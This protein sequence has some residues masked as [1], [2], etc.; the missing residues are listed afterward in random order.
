MFQVTGSDKATQKQ[1]HIQGGS[2]EIYFGEAPKICNFILNWWKFCLNRCERVWCTCFSA[3]PVPTSL[4]ICFWLKLEKY[5]QCWLIHSA[6]SS[7]ASYGKNTS[8]DEI[9]ILQITWQCWLKNEDIFIKW[10]PLKCAKKCNIW[11]LI[12]FKVFWNFLKQRMHR[13]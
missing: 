8:N 9:S 11:E 4:R 1:T 7:L 13:A 2:N 12:L 6:N 10:T 3:S 5:Y